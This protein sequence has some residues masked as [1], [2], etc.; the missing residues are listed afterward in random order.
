MGNSEKWNMLAD[1]SDIYHKKAMVYR[2]FSDAQDSPR[3]IAEFLMQKIKN[4][5]LLDLGC[6][7]GKYTREFGHIAKQYIGLDYSKEQLSSAKSQLK[8][9]NSVHFMQSCAKKINLP[10][11]SVD[12]VLA[13]WLFGSISNLN[14]RKQVL[15]EAKRV[16]KP[17]GSMYVV[18][19]YGYS[20]FERIIQQ[21]KS[22]IEK[23]NKWLSSNGFSIVKEIETYFQ[24]KSIENAKNTFEE[25]WGNNASG[26]IFS[27]RIQQ[28][29]GIY[30]QVNV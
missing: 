1:D 12:T 13:A 16:L 8:N 29:V 17:K 7:S 6:G 27:P 30:K 3:L 21:E 22:C 4:N 11:N 5:V 25:I 2:E 14:K 26:R 28:E 24:F 20:E 10:D 15:A 9:K 19:N 18:E 23:K